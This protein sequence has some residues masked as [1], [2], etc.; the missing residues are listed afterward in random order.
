MTDLIMRIMTEPFMLTV[1]PNVPPREASTSTN[2]VTVLMPARSH[3]D[4]YTQPD[5]QAA[6][7]TAR[8]YH[9]GAGFGA[10]TSTLIF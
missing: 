10:R 6:A 3:G 8:G 1:R 9:G 4:F 7:V 2:T 5:G